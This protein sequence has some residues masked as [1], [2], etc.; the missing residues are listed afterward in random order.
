MDIVCPYRWN[1]VVIN[2]Q[3]QKTNTCCKTSL[4]KIN[5]KFSDPFLNNKTQFQRRQEMLDGL[6]HIA[7]SQCW[8]L[9]RIG[10]ISWRLAANKNREEI[11]SRQG[12]ISNYIDC[13]EL[14]LGN[15]C[16]MKCVYC[17]KEFSTQWAV[18]DFE[19]GRINKKEYTEFVKDLEPNLMKYFWNRIE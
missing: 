18:E 6:K 16:D 9:E 12:V 3:Q 2:L 14:T 19:N 4:N 10:G 17:N 7:C 1:Y 13:L 8:Q 11:A 15:I 5:L